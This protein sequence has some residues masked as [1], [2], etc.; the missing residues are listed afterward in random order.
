MSTVQDRNFAVD[1]AQGRIV[2][3]VDRRQAS[4]EV[5]PAWSNELAGADTERMSIQPYAPLFPRPA[6]ISAVRRFWHPSA[7]G[8]C[9]REACTGPGSLALLVV[10]SRSGESASVEPAIAA[11][12]RPFDVLGV[13]RRNVF[14]VIATPCGLLRATTLSAAVTLA[15]ARRGVKVDVEVVLR[16]RDGIT[17]DDLMKAAGV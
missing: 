7:F 8:K 11:S 15:A 12:T 9:L 16:P 14:G 6:P 2:V 3:D 13:L 10:W 5:E 4:W 1:Q 17:A